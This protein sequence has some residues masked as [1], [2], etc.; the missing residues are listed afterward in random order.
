MVVHS[1]QR[2]KHVRR[3]AAPVRAHARQ[4]HHLLLRNGVPVICSTH[5]GQSVRLF[6]CAH[7]STRPAWH[8]PICC[9][10]AQADD[11]SPIETNILLHAWQHAKH[12]TLDEPCTLGPAPNMGVATPAPASNDTMAAMSRRLLAPGVVERSRSRVR[13]SVA[14]ALAMVRLVYTRSPCTHSMPLSAAQ[15]PGWQTEAA[16]RTRREADACRGTRLQGSRAATL[17]RIQRQRQM[18]WP[19]GQPHA[20]GSRAHGPHPQQE[21]AALRELLGGTAARRRRAQ[22]RARHLPQRLRRRA[23]Q[24]L[25]ARQEAQV[26]VVAHLH[27]AQAAWQPSPRY[28]LQLR[29]QC[30]CHTPT[31]MTP[32]FQWHVILQIKQQDLL[33]YIAQIITQQVL[34]CRQGLLKLPPRHAQN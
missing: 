5:L 13:T 14:P 1:V 15:G 23:V 25:P 31:Q 33:S 7:A 26:P 11:D 20:N 6:L 19:R 28:V 12:E 29:K 2:H 18:H 32:R 10:R 9:T 8:L 4:A 30:Y 21:A 24:E 22:Q 27:A 3:H 17:P 34:H 16:V